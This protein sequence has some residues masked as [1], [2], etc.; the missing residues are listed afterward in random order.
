MNILWSLVMIYDDDH[1][2]D[3]RTKEYTVQYNIRLIIVDRT[4]LNNK[5]YTVSKNIYT[6]VS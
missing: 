6:I 2:V 1:D 5:K 4:Q 3:F